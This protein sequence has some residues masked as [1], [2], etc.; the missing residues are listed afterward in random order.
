MRIGLVQI[1]GR[2]F[3]ESGR[4][5]DAVGGG[6]GDWSCTQFARYNRTHIFGQVINRFS[7]F[8]RVDAA[9]K[10]TD[11]VQESF[12][13][14][15]GLTKLYSMVPHYDM[16]KIDLVSLQPVAMYSWLMTGEQCKHIEQV[17][18]PDLPLVP[19]ERACS[20]RSGGAC[21]SSGPVGK[22]RT[23]NTDFGCAKSSVDA[24][25]D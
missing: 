13:G 3:A 9:S 1:R 16:K 24:L 17:N 10:L 14:R 12:T 22:L 20:S 5:C 25:F 4:I 8:L 6:A 15:E 11:Q 18:V 21:G 19:I 23:K 2:S 7:C